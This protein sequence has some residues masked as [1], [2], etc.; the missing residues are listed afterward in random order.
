[1]NKISYTTQRRVTLNQIHL[2]CFE[3]AYIKQ[4]KH[5]LLAIIEIKKQFIVDS[6]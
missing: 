4:I 6:L 5:F 1:M 2:T 3:I